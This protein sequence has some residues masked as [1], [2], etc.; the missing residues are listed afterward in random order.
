MTADF[1]FDHTRDATR[2]ELRPLYSAILGAG[3]DPSVSLGAI[4]RADAEA[5]LRA[6]HAA[7]IAD[8]QA[9][10]SQY[11]MQKMDLPKR[12]QLVGLTDP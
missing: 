12:V 7:Y 3:P 9:K 2:D 10:R 1:T 8:G 11:I 4:T 5:W 6:Q